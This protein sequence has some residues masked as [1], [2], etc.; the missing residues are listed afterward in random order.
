MKQTTCSPQGEKLLQEWVERLGL[1]DWVI[2]LTDN[3]H[4]S[5]MSMKDVSGCTNWTESIKTATIEII[6]PKFYG[7]RIVPFDYEATLVHELLHLKTSLVSSNTL[8]LEERIMHQLIDD[9]ARALVNAK[10]NG[11]AVTF[12]TADP[13]PK[14]T[15][16]ASF[17]AL[18]RLDTYY[19]VRD[20]ISSSTYFGYNNGSVYRRVTFTYKDKVVAFSLQHENQ[21][22]PVLHMDVGFM[23]NPRYESMKR[24]I[25]TTVGVHQDKNIVPYDLKERG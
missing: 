23:T 2:K 10:R 20:K 11:N 19:I 9:L 13:V 17:T 25:C 24:F 18:E 12:V 14:K 16:N 5:D 1:Q 3:C 6:D 7:E 15:D 8:D 4:P 21:L 22:D